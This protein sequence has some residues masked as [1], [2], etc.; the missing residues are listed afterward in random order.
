MIEA[1]WLTCTDPTAMLDY[2]RGRASDRKL[3]LFACAYSRLQ[4]DLLA[5]K[6][7]RKAIDVAE[8][9]ADGLAGEPE[10][11]SAAAEALRVA[12]EA[13]KAR[14]GASE[15]SPPALAAYAATAAWYTI[16]YQARTAAMT[17]CD[18][19]ATEWYVENQIEMPHTDQL[20]E[21]FGNPFRPVI[22][23]PTWLTPRVL[24]LAA[25]SPSLV[26]FDW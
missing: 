1:D 8:R 5:D 4:R 24:E 21:I 20:R 6:R 11:E 16:F 19:D 10:R 9:Y 13:P 12:S 26:T 15:T 3:R 22:P 17:T 18:A 7:S 2:L 23:N 25:E 14:G